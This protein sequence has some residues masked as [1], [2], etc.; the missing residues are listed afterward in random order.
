M[1]L[2]R[3]CARQQSKS[4]PLARHAAMDCFVALLFAMT[5]QPVE[6]LVGRLWKSGGRLRD[7]PVQKP[8]R[9]L[10]NRRADLLGTPRLLPNVHVQP[11]MIGEL[12]RRGRH[13]FLP[14]EGH[15]MTALAREKRLPADPSIPPG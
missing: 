12:A 5:E 10:C 15:H 8:L 4:S 9:L 1:P 3:H 13:C 6:N 2:H 11:V 7:S 14:T